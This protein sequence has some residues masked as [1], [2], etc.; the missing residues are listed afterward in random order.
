[1]MPFN[2]GSGQ[3]AKMIKAIMDCTI[4]LSKKAKLA[5]LFRMIAKS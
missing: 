2:D 5:Q 3:T 1:M 4:K